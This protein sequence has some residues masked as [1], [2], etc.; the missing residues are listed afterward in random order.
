MYQSIPSTS[1]MP[2]MIVKA[3]DM[4]TG[5]AKMIAVNQVYVNERKN[6]MIVGECGTK[7]EVEIDSVVNKLGK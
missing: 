7:I 2:Y 4:F 3:A 1:V 6:V 5:I